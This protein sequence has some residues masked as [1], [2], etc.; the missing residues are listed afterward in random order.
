MDEKP[1]VPRTAPTPKPIVSSFVEIVGDVPSALSSTNVVPVPV[2]VVRDSSPLPSRSTAPIPALGYSPVVNVK[3]NSPSPSPVVDIGSDSSSS[4][5]I[6]EA[7]TDL[8]SLPFGS[9]V[10]LS[11]SIHSQGE[12]KGYV[13]GCEVGPKAATKMGLL[14]DGVGANSVGAKKSR[15]TPSQETL[16][17]DRVSPLQAPRSIP[18]SSH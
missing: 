13:R 10:N 17:F 5:P 14:E 18:N 11:I 9:T 8:Q 6:M 1:R 2:E 7:H 3:D 15:A 4:S 16:E 12:E